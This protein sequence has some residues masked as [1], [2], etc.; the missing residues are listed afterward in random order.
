MAETEIT[1]GPPGTGKTTALLNKVDE[2]LGRGVPPDRIAYLTFTKQGALEATNRAMEKFKLERRQLPYF[3]TLH[4]LC[5]Q[6]L[7]IATGDVVTTRKLHEFADW[8]GVKFTG[9]WTEDGTFSGFEIGDRIMFMENL[10]RVRMIPLRQQYDMDDDGIP[11]S[12]VDRVSRAYRQWKDH[13]GLLDYTDMLERFLK[14]NIN[15]RLEV[16][17]DDEAQDQSLLQWAVLRKLSQGARRVC[18]AGDDDQALYKWA[19]ADV[20]H[21]IELPGDERVLNRSWRVPAAIQ[22]VAANVIN[23]VTHRRPK[24]WNPRP[25]DGGMVD[26][27]SDFDSFI[28]GDGSV[29]ILTRNLYLIEEIV[30]PV[31]E[32]NGH[33]YEVNGRS[34]V[35]QKILD[36]IQLWEKLRKG[37]TVSAVEAR[38]V[39]EYMS[40]GKGVA[41]GFKTLP[42]IP[43]DQQLN[44]S[45][46]QIRGGLATTAVWYEALDRVG[47][48]EIQYLR[49]ARR[50]GETLLDKPRIKVSTIHGAKGGEAD[51]VVL[52]TEIAKRTWRELP[53]DEDSE[54]RCWYVGI[55]RA[56]QRL[57]VVD[58]T[59]PRRCPWL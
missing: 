49:S 59:T 10:S 2:E 45:D 33:L 39:Y 37:G 53:L 21:L 34:S 12:E 5:Y 17:F 22:S 42:N 51:H 44:M 26:H 30:K 7:N 58:S 56:K 31:L 36:A 38:A 29:L 3:R 16:V 50:Q 9:R 25:G 20:E 28:P 15:L 43:D 19:G 54:R 41:R 18:V 4:S 23:G 52:M 1:L 13:H 6:A 14:S 24:E 27:L 47:E 57:T 48:R 11:W 46:L 40:S 55:T 32:A 35:P 8:A